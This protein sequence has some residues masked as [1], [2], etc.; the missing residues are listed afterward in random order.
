[1]SDDTVTIYRV[2]HSR[3]NV[4]PWHAGKCLQ[5]DE[6]QKLRD[7]MLIWAE[8]S[9]DRMMKGTKE[10][11]PVISYD[12]R[13]EFTEKHVC[14]ADSIQKLRHWICLRDAIIDGLFDAGFTV[15]KYVV[16]EELVTES[17][18]GLQV[19]FRPQD[20]IEIQE[21]TLLALLD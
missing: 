5:G 10:A 17:R 7:T 8:A 2:R 13:G 16:P 14:G 9:F 4:G 1:M 19:A 3:Y 18:S 12:R 11:H 21:L 15:Y 20:A 6:Y